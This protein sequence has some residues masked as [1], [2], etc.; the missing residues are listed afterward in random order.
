[1]GAGGRTGANGGGDVNYSALYGSPAALRCS[2]D[3][4]RGR[5][6]FAALNVWV[7]CL[8]YGRESCWTP[9]AGP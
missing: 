4:L 7:S 8:R 6:T 9:G 2:R 5:Y 3:V 1:V